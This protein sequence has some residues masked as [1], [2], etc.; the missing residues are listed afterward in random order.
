MEITNTGKEVVRR[1]HAEC[2]SCHGRIMLRQEENGDALEVHVDPKSTCQYVDRKKWKTSGLHR[3]ALVRMRDFLLN[4]GSIAVSVMCALCGASLDLNPPPGI[5]QW[6]DEFR[7]TGA[8]GTGSVLDIAGLDKNGAV[9]YAIEI[10]Y[11]HETQNYRGRTGIIWVEICAGEVMQQLDKFEQSNGRQKARLIDI[12]RRHHCQDTQ[13]CAAE[14]KRAEE[15]VKI[16]RVLAAQKTSSEMDEKRRILPIFDE[17]ALKLGLYTHS[18]GWSTKAASTQATKLTAIEWDVFVPYGRCIY[19]ISPDPYIKRQ[20]PYCLSCFRTITPEEDIKRAEKI[21]MMCM[22]SQEKRDWD[23]I[24]DDIA[25]AEHTLEILK[26]KKVSLE[27]R[28]G[29]YEAREMRREAAAKRAADEMQNNP[30]PVKRVK[31]HNKAQW[32][33]D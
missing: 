4:G 17:I 18:D 15:E 24:D 19:C 8:D 10:V 22:R 12:K 7:Y 16:Q 29:D 33:I 26:E 31:L 5:K 30:P 32:V 3:T 20:H 13:A 14:K 21:E 23:T 9:V 25:D 6:K 1:E 11:T 27:K 28:R 2:Q